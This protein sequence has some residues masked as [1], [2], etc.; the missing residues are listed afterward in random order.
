MFLVEC[1]RLRSIGDGLSV[2]GVLAIGGAVARFGASYEQRRIALTKLPE[3]LRVSQSLLLRSC[4]RL[5]RLPLDFEIGRSLQIIDC[6]AL[7]E[8]PRNLRVKGSLTIIGG[9]SLTALPDNLVVEGDL[10]LSG[11]RVTALP[12]GL[13]VGGALII[14]GRC[15]IQ[16]IP[17][18]ISVGGNVT[19]RRVR[20]EALPESWRFTGDLTLRGARKLRALPQRIHVP[21]N[22]DLAD[23]TAL[24]TLP[25]GLTVGGNLILRGC[26]AL[27]ALPDG[28]RIAGRLNLRGCVALTSLGK[29]LN[30][31]NSATNGESSATPASSQTQSR[32]GSRAVA[33]LDIRDC[34]ALEELPD[35]L[36]VAGPIDVAGSAVRDLPKTVAISRLL[37]RGV[38]VPPEVVFHPERLDPLRILSE[39]N[40]EIRRVMLERAGLEAILARAGAKTV[41][42]DTDAGGERRLIHIKRLKHVYLLC[43]CPSTARE[44]LLRI[45]PAMQT[46]RQAA[47]WTAGFDDPDKYR[48][49]LET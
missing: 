20:I 32:R 37:W 12:R 14:E 25:A 26:T 48:P 39:E 8:L 28:L 45:P 23:C 3:R 34:S 43:R 7:E 35:D 10:H 46:C 15:Q 1:P 31:Q 6:D 29:A 49:I 40:A 44:Y 41:D 11:S 16:S 36:R 47:A 24:E 13:R 5:K 21:G 27:R 17:P 38:L 19:L 2:N 33:A 18:D 9:K 4:F 22:L 42:S 30:I